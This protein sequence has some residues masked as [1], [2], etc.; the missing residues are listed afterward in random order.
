MQAILLS[1]VGAIL[2]FIFYLIV[3]SMIASLYYGSWGAYTFVS[4]LAII[5]TVIIVVFEI[6]A[7]INAYGYKA[8][9]IPL[10]GG[11][12]AKW[13]GKLNADSETKG[14]GEATV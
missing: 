9:R 13:S 4:A 12:A 2:G 5:I 3:L 7:M 10:I 14:D 1:A 8:Y 11:L 6:I